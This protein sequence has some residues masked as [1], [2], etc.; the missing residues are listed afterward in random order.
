MESADPR[1]DIEANTS[2]VNRRNRTRIWVTVRVRP[3]NRKERESKVFGLG[4]EVEK[5]GSGLCARR[6]VNGRDREFIAIEREGKRRGWLTI[7]EG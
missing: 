6:G 7:R 5:L 3:M 2:N 4:L 1:S